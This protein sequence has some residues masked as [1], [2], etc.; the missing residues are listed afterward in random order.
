MFRR[1]ERVANEDD[2]QE[3]PEC[4]HEV[5]TPESTATMGN[6]ERHR[7]LLECAGVAPQAELEVVMLWE[8]FQDRMPD[9]Q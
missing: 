8:K 2:G 4:Q 5:T 3:R 6:L 7:D 1:P 9:R